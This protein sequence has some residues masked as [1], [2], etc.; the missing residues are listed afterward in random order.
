M[1]KPMQSPGFSV[2]KCSLNL[3]IFG[4]GLTSHLTSSI[5]LCFCLDYALLDMIRTLCV[6]IAIE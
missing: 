6:T 3:A 1:E 2:D 4:W 5:G